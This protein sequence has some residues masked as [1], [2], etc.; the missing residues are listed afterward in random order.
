MQHGGVQARADQLR[1][2]FGMKPT[3]AALGT[4]TG[5][6]DPDADIHMIGYH[7]GH[8]GGRET[9]IPFT[10]H[11][12][13]D[14]MWEI[15]AACDL[16][17][18]TMPGRIVQNCYLSYLYMCVLDP[19]TEPSQAALVDQERFVD[20]EL[21]AVNAHL[22]LPVGQVATDRVLSEYTTLAH[23][24]PTDMDWRHARDIR[25]RGFLVVPIKDPVTWSGDDRELLVQR[26]QALLASDY[27]QTKG[28]ATMIG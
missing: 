21:R 4:V 7:A 19:G 22:L 14:P 20:A 1:N 18:P 27:R 5:Y 25:G 26:L 15:L 17:A 13:G 12:N 24:L 8:H 6:G 23:K 28:V 16:A 11:P 9:G 10:D 3:C 2:P